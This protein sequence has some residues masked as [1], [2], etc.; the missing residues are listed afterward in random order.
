MNLYHIDTNTQR[1]SRMEG[2]MW[3]ISAYSEWNANYEH[4][5]VMENL[6]TITIWKTHIFPYYCFWFRTLIRLWMNNTYYQPHIYRIMWIIEAN[7]LK[8][9]ASQK[10][11]HWWCWIAIRWRCRH[12]VRCGR[13]HSIQTQATSISFTKNWPRLKLVGEIVTNSRCISKVEIIQIILY[14]HFWTRYCRIRNLNTYRKLWAFKAAIVYVFLC[15]TDSSA[16]KQCPSPRSTR[17]L[18]RQM[19]STLLNGLKRL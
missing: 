1:P 17:Q 5:S 4:F 12:K 6:H 8:H 11:I 16:V 15:M 19:A 10:R 3:V 13:T 2:C 18:G 14:H 9:T 7:C